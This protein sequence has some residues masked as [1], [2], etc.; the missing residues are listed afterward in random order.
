MQ[1][2]TTLG[3]KTALLQGSLRA[4]RALQTEATELARKNEVLLELLGEKTEELEAVQGEVEDLKAH[5]RRQLDELLAQ[6]QQ[7][8]QGQAQG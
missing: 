7:Q 6:Q 3:Q 8:L 4:A 1:E 2:T 5:F